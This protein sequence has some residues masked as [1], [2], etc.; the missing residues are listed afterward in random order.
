MD[1]R[2]AFLKKF[3]G[4]SL[5][6]LHEQSSAEELFQNNSLRPILKLQNE[7]LITSFLHYTVKNKIDFNELSPEKKRQVIEKAIQKDIKFR[8]TLKGIIIGLFTNEEFSQYTTN[9]SNLNKR[10]MTLL[11]ERLQSQL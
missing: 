2:D 11:I 6:T 5:G 8:N 1:N 3:R 4:E 9:A 10:M 7:L